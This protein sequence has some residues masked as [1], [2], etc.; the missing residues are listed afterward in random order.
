M[1]VLRRLSSRRIGSGFAF[2]ICGGKRETGHFKLHK[3]HIS[4]LRHGRLA[5]F[6]DEIGDLAIER[7]AL[8]IERL[9]APLRILGLQ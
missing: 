5:G 2:G 8:R 3:N 7:I 4:K 6:D 9:K 1:G